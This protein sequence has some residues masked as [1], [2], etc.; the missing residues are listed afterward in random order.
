VFLGFLGYF[1]LYSMR[2]NLSVAIVAM[3]DQD[4]IGKVKVQ[5]KSFPIF[6]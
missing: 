5:N 6:I 1:N 4:R 2:T 3:T